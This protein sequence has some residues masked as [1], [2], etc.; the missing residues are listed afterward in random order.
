MSG[1]VSLFGYPPSSVADREPCPAWV[2]RIMAGESVSAP[3]RGSEAQQKIVA[4]AKRHIAQLPGVRIR[5]MDVGQALGVSPVHLTE[6]FRQVEG[7]PFYRYALQQRLERA[8]RL[9]PGYRGDLSALALE[10]DF[11]SHS[12]FTTAF[13]RAF[14]CTP[15][16]FRERARRIC[17]NV[18]SLASRRVETPN[19]SVAA[20]PA[21]LATA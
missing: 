13:R 19:R 20:H 1:A 2:E 3:Q 5:L 10:L 15:A 4:H 18:T 14:G 12:H 16:A 17:R 9:L 21:R 6:V 11:A 7:T 8:V